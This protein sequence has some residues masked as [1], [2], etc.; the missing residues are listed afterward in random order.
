MTYKA[1][2]VDT[3]EYITLDAFPNIKRVRKA[4]NGLRKKI[5][6]V[7]DILNLALVLLMV[8]LAF[9]LGHTTP[10]NS[11]NCAAEDEVVIINNECRHIDAL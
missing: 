4:L 8:V 1:Y 6:M 10:K 7:K 9:T 3:G 11:W 2:N 5:N